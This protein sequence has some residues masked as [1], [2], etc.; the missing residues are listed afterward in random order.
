MG[1][2]RSLPSFSLGP[3]PTRS[4]FPSFMFLRSLQVSCLRLLP[5]IPGC[6]CPSRSFS[7]GPSAHQ[8]PFS[9]VHVFTLPSG[10]DGFLVIVCGGL[11][12][13]FLPLGC[14]RRAC[15][16]PFSLHLSD[17]C[18]A[19]DF[20]LCY[21]GGSFSSFLNI[22]PPLGPPFWSVYVSQSF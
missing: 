4:L 8:V 13:A 22:L 20:S 2:I 12:P 10:S 21:L 19:A 7:Y 3:R 9:L 11:V 6:I 18:F 14:V 1:C 15:A 5:S 16:L 17:V